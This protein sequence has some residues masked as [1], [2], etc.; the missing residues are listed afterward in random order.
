MTWMHAINIDDE[1]RVHVKV[2][3]SNVQHTLEEK[4]DGRS[5]ANVQ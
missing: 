4:A 2:V 3:Q 5:V 1:N